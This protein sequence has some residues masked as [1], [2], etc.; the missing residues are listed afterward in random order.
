MKLSKRT[1]AP[2]VASVSGHRRVLGGMTVG[3]VGKPPKL[4]FRPGVF[5]RLKG[6]LYEVMYCYRIADNPQEWRYSL[7]TRGTLSSEPVD[8]I[9]KLAKAMGLGATTPRI[10]YEVFRSSHDASSFFME[11]PM[12]GDR[13]DVGNQSM[14]RYG[15]VISSGEVL[16]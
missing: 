12:N 15:E 8:D 9:G 5:I 7:E 10:V 11:I 4:R 16:E 13:C 2:S 14:L 1:E 6:Q 3:A